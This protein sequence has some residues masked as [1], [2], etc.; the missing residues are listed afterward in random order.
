MRTENT[1]FLFEGV[2]MCSSCEVG[3]PDSQIINSRVLMN[4][5]YNIAADSP[6]VSF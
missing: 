5:K 2:A 6:L 1:T 3:P 4:T